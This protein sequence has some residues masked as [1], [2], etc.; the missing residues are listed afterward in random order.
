[1]CDGHISVLISF[2]DVKTCHLTINVLRAYQI[3]TFISRPCCTRRGSN[4]WGF[5]AGQKWKLHCLFKSQQ[6]SGKRHWN[7]FIPARIR[8]EINGGAWCPVQQVS[9]DVYEWLQIDLQEL[10][11]ISLVETQGRFGNGQV[12]VSHPYEILMLIDS[13][14]HKSNIN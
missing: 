11:V 8:T 10:K 7:L 3:Y 13:R 12:G 6:F 5:E 14:H 1:M 9:K 4:K 2:R